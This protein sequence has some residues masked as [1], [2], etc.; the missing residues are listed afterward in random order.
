MLV[1]AGSPGASLQ[2]SR[3]GVLHL[4]PLPVRAH[5]CTSLLSPHEA[6][7][8]LLEGSWQTTFPYC[9]SVCAGDRE[10]KGKGFLLGFADGW[11][12]F[13]QGLG[14]SLP[15]FCY[16]ETGMRATGFALTCRQLLR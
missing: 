12:S 15:A 9:L 7:R 11:G 10:P 3:G 1:A 6:G 14:S 2:Q 16:L 8:V 4:L 13:G 5:L